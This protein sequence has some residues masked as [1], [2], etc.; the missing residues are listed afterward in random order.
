MNLIFKSRVNPEN[1]ESSKNT[2]H[3]REMVAMQKKR[4]KDREMEEKRRQKE[5]EK[6]E[7]ERAKR[8]KENEKQRQ[9]E[10][11][12]RKRKEIA[13]QKQK[14]E[15]ENKTH[16]RDSKDKW[17][18]ESPKGDRKRGY[19]SEPRDQ[20]SAHRNR[21]PPGSG[22]MQTYDD[23]N[24]NNS[25]STHLPS[26]SSRKGNRV[27]LSRGSLSSMFPDVDDDSPAVNSMPGLVI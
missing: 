12:D 27:S 15:E 4:D 10:L 14:S 9:K 17:A 5:L 13:E 8:E 2:K 3:D 26:A 11:E 16:R 1:P 20:T 25:A 18:N 23:E 21:P 7:K 24:V 6:Q 19:Q 22:H